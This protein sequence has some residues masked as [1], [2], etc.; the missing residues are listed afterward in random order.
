SLGA[1]IVIACGC[2]LESG[3]R[4][5]VPPERLAAASLV[6][7]GRQ[8]YR[9]TTLPERVRIDATIADRLAQLPGV[10]TALVDRSFP[11]TVL[12]DGKAVDAG[13]SE[14]HA[15]S[16]AVLA[17]Y[18]LR[19]EGTPA[20]AGEVV[21]EAALATDAGL[22]VG[23]EA[24]VVVRGRTEQ[25]RVSGIATPDHQPSGGRRSLFF[26]D[27][28][29][30]RLSGHPDQADAVAVITTPGADPASLL[31]R[32]RATCG[33]GAVVLSGDARGLAEHP[34]ALATRKRLSVLAAIF[35]SWAI[36]ISMFGVASTVALSLQQRHR[37]IALLRALGSTPAQLRRMILIE[38]VAISALSVLLS[39][40][41]GRYLGE[42]LF[43][44]LGHAEVIA[45][46]VRFRAGWLPVVVGAVTAVSAALVAARTAGRTAARTSPA[47]AL[48]TGGEGPWLSRARIVGA[49]IFLTSGI[50]LALVTWLM[51]EGPLTAGTAGPASVLFAIGLACL[52]PGA[53][54]LLLSLLTPP[55]RRAGGVLTRL[56]VTNSRVRVVRTASAVTPL[57]LL[58]GIATGTL[59]LQ[60]TEDAVTAAVF[61]RGLRADYVLTS[62]TGGFDAAVVQRVRALP[63]VAAASAQ[64]TTTGFLRTG[65]RDVIGVSASNAAQSIAAH[66]IDGSLAGLSG[67]S[68]ALSSTDAFELHAEVGSAV[69]V[70]LGDR[71]VLPLRVVAVMEDGPEESRLL[72]PAELAAEH[73]TSRLVPQITVRANG[74]DAHALRGYLDNFAATIPGTRV[75]DRGSLLAADSELR[76]MLASANYA[77][78]AMIVGYAGISVVNQLVASTRRRRRE[79]GLQRLTGMT[80]RQVMTMLGVESGLVVVVGSL[81]GCVSAAVTLVPYCLVKSGSVLPSGSVWTFV[82]VI[83]LAAGLTVVGTLLPAWRVMRV[84]PAEAAASGD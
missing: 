47:E 57:I 42:L 23:Q 66:V 41:P 3:L 9:S 21:L 78:V 36:L 75:D 7:A 82:A 32:V 61:R 8:T 22:G 26:S 27:I 59:Y 63:G 50:S 14:G 76:Q 38:A 67:R 55:L 13:R 70:M 12:R 34:G 5:A 15:W 11:A 6:V 72:V 30:A 84:R 56:A 1:A 28:D 10:D 37:E 25:F 45:G 71:S 81:L 80:C 68:V 29:A 65:R 52:A 51:M 58:V 17:P 83:G 24:D 60:S 39:V 43:R 19:T 44:A 54:R 40:L 2:L 77:V 69:T 73:I 18:R 79:F 62:T 74:Q 33:P 31:D 4:T 16:T 53:T 46:Q 64:V 20:R 49:T 35:G 48:A